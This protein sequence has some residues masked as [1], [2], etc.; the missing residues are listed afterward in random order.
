MKNYFK[1]HEGKLRCVEGDLNVNYQKECREAIEYETNL[2]VKSA[3]LQILTFNNDVEP[4][5]A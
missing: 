3:V 4:E 2:R 1:D 5:V